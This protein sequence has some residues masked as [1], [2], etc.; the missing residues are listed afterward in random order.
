MNVVRNP[1]TIADKH[2]TRCARA[3]AVGILAL[4]LGGCAGLSARVASEPVLAA[5]LHSCLALFDAADARIDAGGV[6]DAQDTRIVGFPYLRVN[7]LLQRLA[8]GADSA[9]LGDWAGRLA[10]LDR[11]ARLI[12]LANLAAHARNDLED[13]A[14][15][16]HNM[17]LADSLSSCRERLVTHDRGDAER[18]RILRERAVVP[19]EYSSFRRVLGLYA[20]SGIV[21]SA[22][23]RRLEARL[24]ST[25]DSAFLQ[26]AGVL[27]RYSPPSAERLRPDEVRSILRRSAANAFGLPEPSGTDLERLFAAFAPQFVVD[28]TGSYDR[29]GALHWADA[30]LIAVDIDDAVVYRRLAHTLVGDQA[31]LQL[32]YTAWFPARPAQSRF[33]LL[34]GRLDG[35]VWRVTL[36]P[37]GEPWLFDSMHPC[38]CYHQFFATQ[39]AQP[40]ASPNALEE[41]AFTPLRLPRLR[42]GERVSVRLATRTHYIERV[43]LGVETE[44]HRIYRFAAED[45]LRS[46]PYPGGGRRG[47]FGSDGIIAG[48]ERLE[49]FLFWPMGI[50]NPGAMR[51]WGRHATAFVGER[52]FDDP[53]LLDKR[54]RLPARND[55]F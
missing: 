48:S 8:A 6:R 50:V 54:F 32:V 36:T 5:H 24:Q 22:G 26:P 19:P 25:F 28:E 31:L 33:D 16:R 12:E 41:W 7:R 43:E 21:F 9:Q 40:R 17:G 51:Q 35:I 49:R 47:A 1:C 37:D 3:W 34:A 55:G 18:M 45:D 39:N 10:A 15:E 14:R 27:V 52:H 46:L 29:I 4:M 44:S 13:L 11:S 30:G 2:L 53:D 20:L 23:V 42:A 38:G